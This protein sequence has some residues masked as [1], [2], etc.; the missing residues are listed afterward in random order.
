MAKRQ[1]D[2]EKMTTEE[3]VEFD[4][5]NLDV[6][7]WSAYNK[8]LAYGYGHFDVMTYIKYSSS[9]RI[10]NACNKALPKFDL[11]LA[12]MHPEQY[13]RVLAFMSKHKDFYDNYD[14]VFRKHEMEQLLGYRIDGKYDSLFEQPAKV[15]VVEAD[16][17]LTAEVAGDLGCPF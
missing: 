4:Q 16:P 15:E 9:D 1:T 7:Q 6:T 14:G 8:L 13:G 10:I 5:S 11:H 3:R 12:I 17:E 2:P